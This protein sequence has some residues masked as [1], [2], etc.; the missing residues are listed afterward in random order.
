DHWN[1]KVATGKSYALNGHAGP[2]NV[3]HFHLI[4]DRAAEEHPEAE[5]S[6]QGKGNTA[7]VGDAPPAVPAEEQIDDRTKPT[8]QVVA[9]QSPIPVTSPGPDEEQVVREDQAKSTPRRQDWLSGAKTTFNVVE[10]ISG[11]IPVIGSY[12]GA[13]AKVGAAIVEIVQKMGSNKETAD[14]LDSNAQQLSDILKLFENGMVDQ[15]K[16][17]L[18][19]I[20]NDLQRE[21]Q[22]VQRK[23]EEMNKSGVLQKA[24]SAKDRADELRGYQETIRTASEQLQLLVTL[25]TTTLITE[26]YNKGTREEQQR[27]LDRLGDARY[28]TRGTAIE[29]VIC[30]EGTRVQTL[31]SI[32][33]WIRNTSTSENVL[34]IRGMAGRGKSTIASTVA[35]HWKYQAASAIFHFRRGENELDKRLVCA[36][37]RQLGSNNLIPEVRDSIL[38]S[39]QENQDIGQDR[40]RDQFQTLFIRALGRLQNR[41]LPILLIVDALDE[42]QDV[43]Y[44]VSFVKLIEQFIPSLP[45]NVKFLLTTRPEAPLIRALEPREWHA[46][47]LDSMAN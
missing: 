42:C 14:G 29:D 31:E 9:P 21:L 12:V 10:G 30:L 35:H 3:S 22:G 7:I 33:A 26:L 47:D 28:G 41:S 46:E 43:E 36:L 2:E 38:Q 6:S 15:P 25:N 23:I 13:A 19:K 16:D 34:W 8:P 1:H 37:A 20:F 32:N 17:G 5:S 39:I 44:A 11:T 4:V 45:V 27:L 18:T 40:L 24:F